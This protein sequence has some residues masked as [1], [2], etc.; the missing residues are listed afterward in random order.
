M[1]LTIKQILDSYK[2]IAVVGLSNKP[3]R[4]SYQVAEYMQQNGYRIIP[5]NPNI[6]EVLGEICYSSLSAIPVA[7]DIV[8]I[9]Q[10]S[11]KVLPYV[12]EAIKLKTKAIWMQLEI[13][14]HE[15]AA[16]AQSNGLSVVMDKC[17]KIE[18]QF[19]S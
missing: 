1:N 19:L 9:F 14:H 5:V 3:H 11:E 16:K 7:F 15:A 6:T 12:E 10:R 18:H 2:T 17:I 8:N 13:I 4:A